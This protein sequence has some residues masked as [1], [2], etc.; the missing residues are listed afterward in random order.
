[1]RCANRASQQTNKL[2]RHE[3]DVV[4]TRGQLLE[5]VGTSLVVVHGHVAWQRHCGPLASGA[6]PRLASLLFSF[7]LYLCVLFSVAN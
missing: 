1:M 6:S 7:L 5:R 2:T 4:V 3:E